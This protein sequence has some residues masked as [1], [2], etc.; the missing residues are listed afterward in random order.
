MLPTSQWVWKQIL[1]VRTQTL[2]YLLDSAWLDHGYFELYSGSDL[3]FVLFI[4]ILL[5]ARDDI[6]SKTT[7]L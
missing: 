5:G 7:L 1:H 4:L 6:E 3:I 2:G